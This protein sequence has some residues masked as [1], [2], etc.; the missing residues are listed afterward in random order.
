MSDE[1]Q[2]LPL[3][4]DSATVFRPLRSRVIYLL[5]GACFL[6]LCGSCAVFSNA[7]DPEAVGIKIWDD[8]QVE[9]TIVVHL[10]SVDTVRCD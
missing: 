8:P 4:A 6:G 2:I 7:N 5:V 9:G 3:T 10:D 1:K